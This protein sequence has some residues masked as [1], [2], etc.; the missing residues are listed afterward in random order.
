MIPLLATGAGSFPVTAATTEK[1][2]IVVVSFILLVNWAI[3]VC[4]LVST[5]GWQKKKK[6]ETSHLVAALKRSCGSLTYRVPWY[7]YWHP[8]TPPLSLTPLPPQ[9]C[10]RSMAILP[11]AIENTVAV[12][13]VSIITSFFGVLCVFTAFMMLMGKRVH[14]K[15]Q[16]YLLLNVIGATLLFISLGISSL[17]GSLGAIP[18]CILQIIWGGVSLH[19]FIKVRR[20]AK[21]KGQNMRMS[22]PDPLGALRFKNEHDEEDP[23]HPPTVKQIIISQK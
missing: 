13:T 10:L 18:I 6:Q 22:L 21:G 23:D 15:S 17:V 1:R 11:A 7:Y 19:T 9:S 4:L 3:F 5:K 20:I 16:R 12:E 2:R 8:S 14:P